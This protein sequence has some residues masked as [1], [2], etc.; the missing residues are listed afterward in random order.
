MDHAHIKGMGLFLILF[1][2]FTGWSEVIKIVDRKATSIKQILRTI[3]S[4]NG[5]PKT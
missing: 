3:F 5:V 4:R 1:D 2:S